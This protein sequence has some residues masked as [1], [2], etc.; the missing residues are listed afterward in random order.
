MN[1]KLRDWGL[2]EETEKTRGENAWKHSLPFFVYLI[3]TITQTQW[4]TCR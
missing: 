3:V 1:C 2:Y 4:Q